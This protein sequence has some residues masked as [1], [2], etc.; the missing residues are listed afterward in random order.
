MMEH[1]GNYVLII[2]SSNIDFNIYLERLPQ[3]GETV[4]GAKFRQYWGGKGANQAVACQRSGTQ[5]IFIGKIG[6]DIF[7]EQMISQLTKEGIDTSHIF[8][9]PIESSGIAFIVIDKHGENMIT[10]APGAN[11]NLTSEDIRKKSDIIRHASVLIVQMEIPIETIL[12]IF[13]IA[14]NGNVIKILNPA[15]LKPIPLEILEK[16]DLLIP[17]EGELI[18]L[19]SMLNL[20]LLPDDPGKKIFHASRNISEL[21]VPNIITTLGSKGAAIYQ[22]EED[23]FMKLPAFK[24][25]AVDTVGAGDC[26]NGVLA[27]KVSQGENIINAVKYA[28]SAASIAVTRTGAQESMPFQNE[29]EK[30]FKEY[31]Q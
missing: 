15:P 12:E 21:G 5:T 7:G 6:K 8:R 3:P 17:N 24:V 22:A 11:F 27:S 2:G 19:N 10:V 25:K 18:K 14:N 13:E 4:T 29:I 23:S 16:L 26:F 1:I 20:K 30:R 31:N 28:I 9:D